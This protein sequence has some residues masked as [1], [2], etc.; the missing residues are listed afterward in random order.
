MYL[1]MKLV[2][3]VFP[4]ELQG[5]GVISSMGER[6]VNDSDHLLNTEG[7]R[8]E[9]LDDG[10]MNQLGDY[11]FK[12]PLC[13]ITSFSACPEQVYLGISGFFLT[14]RPVFVSTAFSSITWVSHFRYLP[15]IYD[16]FV[17]FAIHIRSPI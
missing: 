6:L 9:P 11:A 8:T 3:H 2:I 16:S 13:C 17:P 14:K 5:S 1:I 15:A 4:S 10:E 12:W 7:Q